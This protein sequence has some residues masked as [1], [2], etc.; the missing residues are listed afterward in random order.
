MSDTTQRANVDAGEVHKFDQLAGDWWNPDGASAPLHR[1]NPLRLDYIER[2]AGFE[3]ADVLDVGCGGGLLSEGMA[4]R[5]ARV[6][7]IDLA[8]RALEVARDHAAQEQL[9]IDYREISAESMAAEQPAAFDLV[10]C[11]EMLEHVPDPGAVVRACAQLVK[12]GGHVVFST[13][14]RTP[15][16]F[17]LAIVA[18]EHLLGLLPRG[19]HDYR[20]FLRPSEIAGP[21]R[22]E[23]LEVID[24]TGMHYH[25][26]TGSFS[27]GPGVAVNYLMAC[28]RVSP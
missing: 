18:A 22:A 21:A 3:G 28:R 15:Q 23:G 19:T 2:I 13:I 11:L 5:G 10:T 27:L 8:A 24:L 12:P 16:A 26:L 14:N 6:T 20:G 17:A 7:G 25:P 9:D 4:R 1:I